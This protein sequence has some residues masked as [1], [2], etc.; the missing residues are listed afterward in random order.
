MKHPMKAL[1]FS[2]ILSALLILLQIAWYAIFTISY[3]THGQVEGAD[4]RWFYAVGK[5]ARQYGLDEVYNL[6]YAAKAQAQV[7][8][9]PVGE[10]QILL[11]N[12]P[13][14]I[15]PVMALL[16]GLDYRQAYV[17]NYFG[18]LIVTAVFTGVLYR[19]LRKKDW[20]RFDATLLS[21]SV[22]LF[23]PFFISVLK[24]QDTYI[25]LIGGLFLLI[26]ILDDKDWLAGIGLGLM[27]IRPQI[28]LLLAL[29]FLFRRRKVWWWFLA[30]AAL[31]GIY[32][33]IQIGWSGIKEYV[34][35]LGLS[36]GVEGFGRDES[37]MFDAVGL[38]IRLIP[39]LDINIIHLLGWFIYLVSIIGL[40]ALWKS[41]KDIKLW[42]LSLALALSLF[43][44]PHLHYHDLA[45]LAIPLVGWGI[46]GVKVRRL[47]TCDAVVMP[48]II[49]VFLIL[50]EFWDPVR[51][52]IPY[53]LMIGLPA[54]TACYEQKKATV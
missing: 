50:S 31:L 16:A 47:S 19:F 28:S 4:F 15:F 51:Y 38:M 44:A 43:A 33:F 29:P 35:V 26:A 18:I 25:L 23:E 3:I 13:P 22:L 5:V 7:A 46:M 20:S 54:I 9:K 40:S 8:N 27:L 6:E 53:L 24:G 30:A 45:L 1:R 42:Q 34:V 14:F 21:A 37:A 10:E 36:T 49:S 39:G 41:S 48:M 32:C 17:T 52:T 12:H 11:P 2:Y